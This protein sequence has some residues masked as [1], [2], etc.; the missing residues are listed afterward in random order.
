MFKMHI[1]AVVHRER[2]IRVLFWAARVGAGIL[3]RLHLQDIPLDTRVEAT[4]VH[5]F[6]NDHSGLGV[7]LAD[8][9]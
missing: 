3:L 5:P 1:E 6:T 7:R 9:H 8:V 2:D 4:Q